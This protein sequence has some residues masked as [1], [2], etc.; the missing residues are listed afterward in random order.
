MSLDVLFTILSLNFEDTDHRSQQNK[1]KPDI[2]IS[3]N[4]SPIYAQ[5]LQKTIFTFA[6]LVALLYFY[7]RGFL[8]FEVP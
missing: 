6:L 8:V 1:S 2:E 3:L 5:L 7:L 4:M